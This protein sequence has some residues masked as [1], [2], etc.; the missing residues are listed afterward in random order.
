MAELVLSRGSFRSLPKAGSC[1]FGDNEPSHP[2]GWR[3]TQRAET[4]WRRRA[5]HGLSGATQRCLSLDAARE[6]G[7]RDAQ[8][9]VPEL[10]VERFVRAI[11]PGLARIDER[12]VD[13][14]SLQPAEQSGRDELRPVVPS[15][16][17]VK[18]GQVLL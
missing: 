4:Q 7:I 9:F 18:A 17:E 3:V 8:A 15:E 2:A 1:A 5:S 10:P 14:R 12:R 11:L 16:R 6:L 13:L